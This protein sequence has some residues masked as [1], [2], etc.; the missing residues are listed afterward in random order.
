MV[1]EISARSE[2]RKIG[3][4]TATGTAGRGAPVTSLSEKVDNA[5]NEAR[6][7]ILGVQVL[8]GF[9]YRGFFEA[10]F[11]RLGSAER[12]GKLVGLVLLL[13]ALA[14]LISP[15]PF[16]RIVED[17]RQT[18]RLHRF[19][20]RATEWA[21]LP[22]AFALGLDFFVVGTLVAGPPWGA[23]FAVAAAGTAL[24]FW[25]GFGLAS[26]RRRR[27]PEGI[28]NAKND[29]KT[30]IDERIRNVLTET[31]M[32]LP[33]AQA[34]L[35][36]QLVTVLMDSF[37]RLPSSS[38][39]VHLASLA[40]I[41]LATILLMTPAAWHRLVEQ[42]E[43]TER[44]DRV[45]GRFVIASMVPLALGIAGDVY[46]VF[47]KVTGSPGAGIAAGIG[48]LALFYGVWFGLTLAVR[49]REG[50]KRRIR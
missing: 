32:I 21:L 46:V 31:R 43:N 48:A 10:R 23:V 42:G 13:V 45:A 9:Q 27:R 12:A 14:L 40:A 7:L 33:G 17:G 25:Y 39:A 6:T 34:L 44:F 3:R 5:L 28:M 11:E 22:I 30:S 37:P 24:F 18:S 36:F 50:G 19:A 35:G 2:T 49:A 29:A 20:T 8:L 1:F 26:P 4:M 47:R 38:Q 16:Q 41:T 15:A